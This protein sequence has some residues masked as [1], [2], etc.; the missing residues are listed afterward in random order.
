MWKNAKGMFDIGCQTILE[1][2]G[3]LALISF[4][5]EIYMQCPD[6]NSVPRFD[7]KLQIRQLNR[8]VTKNI[9]EMCD[10]QTVFSNNI[11]NIDN[12]PNIHR[13]IGL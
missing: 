5:K 2:K 9:H 3:M 12:F 10:F 11:S 8:N 7:V 13:R 4:S 6:W 1:R